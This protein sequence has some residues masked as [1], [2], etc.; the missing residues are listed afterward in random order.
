[1]K[2]NQ[3]K[4]SPAHISDNF[5]ELVC[6]NSLKSK[7]ITNA[8]GLLKEEMK[9]LKSLFVKAAL[10]S[11][12]P[13][14]NALAV[15][16]DKFSKY[17]TEEIKKEPNIEIIYEEVKDISKLQGITVIATGPLTSEELSNNISTLRGIAIAIYA[18]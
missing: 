12:V 13:A 2:W 16:R 14:G 7:E 15:D 4:K 9:R 6:S 11:E 1:M 8:C 17:I 5:A 18:R 3:K 10:D